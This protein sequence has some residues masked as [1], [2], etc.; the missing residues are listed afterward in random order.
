MPNQRRLK[1]GSVVRRV[2]SSIVGV[3]ISTAYKRRLRV[4]GQIFA[5]NTRVRLDE[6][7]PE[8]IHR[9]R[10]R[11]A[12]PHTVHVIGAR[13]LYTMHGNSEDFPILQSLSGD[14]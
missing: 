14:R 11:L 1:V 5:D 13:T 10:P 3:V 6:L 4:V 7:N 9:V 8:F 12:L 2:T